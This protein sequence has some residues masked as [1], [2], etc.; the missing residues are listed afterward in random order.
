[1]IGGEDGEGEA[2]AGC[3]I[4]DCSINHWSSTSA[5]MNM[6]TARDTHT[7]AVLVGKIIVA[8]GWSGRRRL[9]SMEF[10]DA[11]E[12]LEYAPLD[13]LLPQIYFN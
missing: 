4:H 5:S 1:M 13:Y 6:I 11:R 10:L 12:I 7:A 8:G 2:S 3:L 9:Y